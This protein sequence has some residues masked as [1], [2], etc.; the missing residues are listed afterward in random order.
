MSITET[1][2]EKK[3]ICFFSVTANNTQHRALSVTSGSQI[4]LVKSYGEAFCGK[5]MIEA[6]CQP[7]IHGSRSRSRR[8]GQYI[9]AL[10]GPCLALQH[11]VSA[12]YVQWQTDFLTECSVTAHKFLKDSQHTQHTHTGHSPLLGE[13]NTFNAKAG[14]ILCMGSEY[15]LCV[16]IVGIIK[17]NTD[18]IKDSG[19]EYNRLLFWSSV[20]RSSI[21]TQHINT[22]A[23]ASSTP[24]PKSLLQDGNTTHT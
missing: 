9:K 13:W 22:C 17:K 10:G 8:D 7:I 14:S 1:K 23:Q 19:M 4:I 6:I 3:G 18:S 21:E 2:N 12:W 15:D 24:P 5:T 20:L 11:L 16:Y